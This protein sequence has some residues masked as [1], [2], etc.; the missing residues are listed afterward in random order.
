MQSALS[1]Y[2]D[3]APS[4]SVLM[5][6]SVTGRGRQLLQ[7][8]DEHRAQIDQLLCQH[9]AIV[10][11]GLKLNTC[12]QF[13]RLLTGLW[14]Q[15]L[16]EYR[17]RSTPRTCLK[18]RIYSSTEYPPEESIPLHNENAYSHT[19]AMRLALA[20]LIPAQS[21]GVTPLAD[22]RKVYQ[23]IPPSLRQRFDDLGVLYVRHYGVLDLSWQE[24]FQTEQRDEVD[25]YC[26]Q[27]DIE[28]Q[29]HD[30]GS[31]TTRERRP[32]SACHPRTGERVWFNQ[33]HLFHL[34][35][36]RP[37]IQQ[38]LLNSLGTERLPRNSYY[39]DG[40]PIDDAD[41]ALIRAAY[42]EEAIRRPWRMG[43]VVLLDNM[44]YAHGRDPFTGPRKVLVGMA[45][46]YPPT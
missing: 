11:P 26:R 38:S 21:G 7:W 34:S 18:G 35:N 8:A 42:A 30:D 6:I 20:C 46:P 43:D 33:A 12:A 27:H 19:W 4:K 3:L 23:R 5:E 13:E 1:E 9:G 40:S 28:F 45:D 29:W 2:Q 44:L 17:N 36:Y 39:G 22:S 37:E 41:L 16:L 24:V 14:G 10:L 31:L 32:A 25:Q 15:E